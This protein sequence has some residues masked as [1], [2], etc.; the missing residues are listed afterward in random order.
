MRSS[1]SAVRPAAHS[2]EF[3]DK[4]LTH[5]ATGA[6]Y[7]TGGTGAPLDFISCHLKGTNWP[8]PGEPVRPSLGKMMDRLNGFFQVI[9][10]H[11]TLSGL[12]VL[13]DE[14]DI[15]VGTIMGVHDNPNLAYRNTEYYAGFLCRMVKHILDTA[16]RYKLKVELATTTAFYFEGKPAFEGN[17]TLFDTSGLEKPVFEALRL[18][19][20]LG[21]ER[22][23]L[24]S[25][26]SVATDLARS[27]DGLA[28]RGPPTARWPWLPGTSTRTRRP[29]ARRKRAWWWRGCRPA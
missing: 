11:P 23:P 5:C 21:H 10:K 9:K 20:H 15:D 7:V 3:L 14:A 4:F 28:T 26:E 22:L 18:L 8:Y 24:Q 1:K 2:P 13:V 25:S 12:E 27:V 17:R 16:E 19:A 6:N 29:K